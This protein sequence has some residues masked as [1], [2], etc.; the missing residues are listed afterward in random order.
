MDTKSYFK[1]H[2]LNKI[3]LA[4]AQTLA[5]N[6][7]DLA[8]AIVEMSHESR[9]QSIALTKLEEACFFAKKALAIDPNNQEV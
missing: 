7:E 2:K 6:F 9:E 8:N 1:V 3:G 5:N 4:K